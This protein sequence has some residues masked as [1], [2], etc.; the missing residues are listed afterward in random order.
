MNNPWSDWIPGVLSKKQ[1]RKL[2]TDNYILDAK[3]DDLFFDHSSFDLTLSRD[4]F[5]LKKGAVK[6]QDSYITFIS[7]EKDLLE[8]LPLNNGQFFL[9]A[10]KTYVFKI[11]QR[12]NT[13]LK[14]SP[15]FGQATAKSTVGRLD[16]LFQEHKVACV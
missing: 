2:C 8:P 1:L 9:E 16:V 7:R 5:W 4:A 10:R 14:E 11:E 6:P 12:L 15:I 3:D 13:K